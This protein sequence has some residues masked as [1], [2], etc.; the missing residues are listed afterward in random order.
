MAPRIFRHSTQCYRKQPL[1]QISEHLRHLRGLTVHDVR[2]RTQF[3]NKMRKCLRVWG[4]AR[5]VAL[6]FILLAQKETDLHKKAQYSLFAQ[7]ALMLYSQ[8]VKPNLNSCIQ[9]ESQLCDIHDPNDIYVFAPPRN[10]SIADWNDY[11]CRHRTR[12]EKND[13]I[14]IFARFNIQN[15]LR[16]SAG[17]GTTYQFTGEEVF[18]FGLTKMATG[19]DNVNLCLHIFGGPPNRWSRAFKWFVI[20]VTDRYRNLISIQGLE[21]VVDRFPSFARTICRRYNKASEVFDSQSNTYVSRAET[22]IEEDNYTIF[23]FHDGRYQRTSTPGTGPNGDFEDGNRRPNAYIMQGAV[24]TGYK[25][26][27]G[28]DTI[29]LMTP[30]GIDYIFEPVSAR[31][32]DNG[33]MNMGEIDNFLYDIQEHHD[34]G[35]RKYK[36]HGDRIFGLGRCCNRDRLPT[37]N[38]PVHRVERAEQKRQRTVREFIEHDFTVML[39]KSH[40]LSCPRELKLN[41]K[42]AIAKEILMLAHLLKNI[43]TCLYGNQVNGIYAFDS[44]P[45]TLNEYLN[46]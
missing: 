8:N 33:A 12:F 21:R 16:I 11:E 39:S 6:H 5:Y 10:R 45:L 22:F 30:D 42:Y 23:C 35:G 17:G 44:D 20:Y 1:R 13:L 27:H 28:L 19:L 40:I 29:T 24:Y 31:V 32:G 36:S 46:P 15:D 4:N 25:K 14:E 26:L 38:N 7:A 3:Q 41:A 37:P 43:S 18:L 34:P 9:L 2:R